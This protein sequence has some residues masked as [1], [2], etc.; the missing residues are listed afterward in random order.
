MV[1]IFNNLRGVDLNEGCPKVGQ[2]IFSYPGE[3]IH[4]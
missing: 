4:S 2:L 3:T 1:I